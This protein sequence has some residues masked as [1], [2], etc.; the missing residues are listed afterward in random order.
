MKLGLQLGFGVIARPV[1]PQGVGGAVM[2]DP[3]DLVLA[4]R[5]K[6][7]LR[8]LEAPLR[9]SFFDHTRHG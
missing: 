9:Q 6:P 2:I 1:E 8:A 5:D 7:V 3:V 4:R